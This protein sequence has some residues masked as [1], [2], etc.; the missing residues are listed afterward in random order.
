MRQIVA[1]L[2]TTTII[3]VFALFPLTANAQQTITAIPSGMHKCLSLVVSTNS[4]L[5]GAKS[6]MGGN[7]TVSNTDKEVASIEGCILHWER[8]YPN[9]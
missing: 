1:T 6:A 4:L 2:A 3:L 7:V 5:S 8:L 9:G